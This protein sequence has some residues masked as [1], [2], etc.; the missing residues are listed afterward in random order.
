MK[1]DTDWRKVGPKP[2]RVLSYLQITPVSICHGILKNQTFMVV[3]AAGE[4]P[5]PPPQPVVFLE[6]ALFVRL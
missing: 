1:D 2:V 6:G 4:L 5:K 3:G